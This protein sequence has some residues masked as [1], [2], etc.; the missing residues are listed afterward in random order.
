[1]MPGWKG[2]PVDRW[3]EEELNPQIHS[4]ESCLETVLLSSSVPI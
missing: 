3:E 2:L 1:M 4:D